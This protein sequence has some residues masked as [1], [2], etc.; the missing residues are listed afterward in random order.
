MKKKER[1]E[2]VISTLE[3]LYPTTPIPLLHKDSYTLLIAVLLSAQCTDARVNTITPKLFALADNPTDMIKLSVEN[4]ESNHHTTLHF[5]L[6][7]HVRLV[8]PEIVTYEL[9]CLLD[10]DNGK[11]YMSL[12]NTHTNEY[13]Q[14]LYT[15]NKD[16]TDYFKKYFE[17]NTDKFLTVKVVTIKIDK[18]HRIENDRLLEKIVHVDGFDMKHLYDH[19]HNHHH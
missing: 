11:Q 6:K 16:L 14:D 3:N 18:L 9:A 17:T 7:H 2:F 13:K 19:H 4:F 10:N 8:C 1:V 5:G 12:L 15:D